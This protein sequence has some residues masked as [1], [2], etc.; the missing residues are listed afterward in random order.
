MVFASAHGFA[1]PRRAGSEVAGAKPAGACLFAGVDRGGVEAPP[2]LWPSS[3]T[4]KEPTGG[5][6]G[7]GSDSPRGDSTARDPP[8]PAASSIESR[9][10]RSEITSVVCGSKSMVLACRRAA[11][12]PALL[13]VGG[14]DSVRRRSANPGRSGVQRPTR[15]CSS[16][17]SA[18]KSG[19][20]LASQ[21]DRPCGFVARCFRSTRARAPFRLNG[22]DR[23]DALRDPVGPPLE[24]GVRE[25]S[26]WKS[27]CVSD[28][29]RSMHR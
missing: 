9:V 22:R 2:E 10:C 12:S 17:E 18:Q 3:A 29:N 5:P 20:H 26:R 19:F 8:G 28:R 4:S 24:A 13:P 25:T 23:A 16:H 11:A 6:M 14:L 7:M 21:P 15:E 27:G 1:S